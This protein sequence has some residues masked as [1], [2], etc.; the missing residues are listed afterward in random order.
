MHKFQDA[1]ISYGRADSKQFAKRLNDR[2]VEAG[3]EV[4][5]DFDDI[6]LG[7]DYQNQINDG[8]EKAD[9]FVFIISPHSV[10][11][12]YCAK[13]IE[14]ALKLNKRIIPLLHVE[15]I[16]LETWQQRHPYDQAADW[17][18][19]RDQGLH[20]SFPNMHPEISKINWVYFREE[21]D[22]FEAGVVGLRSILARQQ[23]YVRQHTLL[24]DKALEWQQ[25]QR[26]STYLLTADAL[27]EAD[28]WL[29]TRFK[30]EQP[31]CL[32]TELHCE[33]ITESL[34]GA[35]D[36]MTQIFVSYSEED[37]EIQEK[38]RKRLVREGFTVWINTQD[39]QTA[40]D[41]Q[42][43][44]NR[45]IEKANTIVL[46]LSPNSLASKY[47]RQE[48]D[49]GRKYHKR[50]IPL[51]VKHTDLD[52]LPD[53]LRTLQF[54]DF[55]TLAS[56]THFDRAVDELI[57]ALG[58]AADYADR[59]KR[60]LVKAL[61]WERQGRDR[62]FLLRG[63][64]FT[65][66]QA[67]LAQPVPVNLTPTDLH[68]TYLQASQGGN[69]FYDAFISYG[70]ADSKVFAT[71]LDQRLR[72]QGLQVWFD[73]NDIPMGVDYQ[74]QIDDGIEKSHTFLFVIAPHSVNSPYCAKEIE[75]AVRLN[76][77]ILPILHVEEISYSTWK[78]RNPGK[79]RD[80]WQ[81][82]KSQGKHASEPNLHPNISK[83]NWIKAREETD[84][85]EAALAEL[86]ELIHRHEGYVQQHT[87]F[88]IRALAWDRHQRQTS[89]LLMGEE[90]LNAQVWL[91][92][93]FE[94]E[95]PPCLPTAL[96]AEFITESTKAADGG[97]TQVF[98]SYAQE[99]RQV[100]EQVQRHLLQAG[101]TVWADTV[102]IHTG[103]D[104]E[105]AIQRGVEEADN[106]VYLISQTALKSVYC[107]QEIEQAL[108]LNKRIIPML[109]EELD[110]SQLTEEV[111]T[112]Q[113]INLAD[114]QVSL[115]L[116]EDLAKLLRTI[117]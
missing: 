26:Q 100:K 113:F 106:I 116:A 110:L 5:F 101:I 19:Y 27:A 65:E 72:E 57:R 91:T 62:K 98:I 10:N 7:V 31:P 1:F 55:S 33:F 43:A 54:I 79:S 111:K 81:R 4:W 15:E 38:I 112:I 89:Y 68:E 48:I 102:D 107:Q 51:L 97:M 60:I 23:R 14:L 117:R 45:G 85:V 71:Q 82:Y 24:L 17:E 95:Q 42:G 36:Q 37:I 104:F 30:E 73:Q 6:P 59:H 32:P 13:E 29:H 94:H 25:H 88:L 105:V 84:D 28:T 21:L 109:L 34:K 96:H 53:D 12:D 87:E 2:L 70:R 52:T 103:E 20:S 18:A 75:L 8:I 114:N 67:W 9:N 3:L 22:D 78:S 64:A 40:E 74:Q 93:Q 44:I 90:R 35:D 11:S 108:A 39:I 76:K 47:C 41:F 56:E 80:D 77:R 58:E 115:D 99:N 61:A 86:V 46:L 83:I 50:I 69:Q 92:K 66:A 49:Y 63:T 16:S